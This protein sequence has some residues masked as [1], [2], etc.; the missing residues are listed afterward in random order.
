MHV[1]SDPEGKEAQQILHDYTLP[2]IKQHVAE[3]AGVNEPTGMEVTSGLH[4]PMLMQVHAN[5]APGAN[6]W[7]RGH[8]H[9]LEHLYPQL[10]PPGPGGQHEEAAERAGAGGDAALV[11]QFQRKNHG[12]ALQDC[13]QVL[14][15]QWS[16]VTGMPLMP[17]Y[18]PTRVLDWCT[19]INP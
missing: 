5:P 17:A 11:P 19:V 4:I 10:Q 15:P 14:Q 13:G 1:L 6:Q 3:A 16:G 2:L 7:S 8:R 9:R 18:H 12:G